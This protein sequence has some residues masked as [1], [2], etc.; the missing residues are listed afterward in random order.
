MHK[1]D[2]QQLWRQFY[3]QQYLPGKDAEIKP[4]Y[5]TPEEEKMLE[6]SNEQFQEE[7]N[8]VSMIQDHFLT[9]L[10]SD[11]W[12]QNMTNAEILMA[13]NLNPENQMLSRRLGFILRTK[14]NLKQGKSCGRRVYP[15]P[16]KRPGTNYNH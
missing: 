3:D 2:M 9:D 7:D 13:M 5:L 11:E 8:L 6:E 14:F 10:S 1:I 16:A 4:W 15:M 12:D